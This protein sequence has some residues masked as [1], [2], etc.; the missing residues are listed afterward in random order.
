MAVPGT[1]LSAKNASV[2]IDGNI[3]YAEE[4]DVEPEAALIEGNSFEGGGYE[5]DIFGLIKATVTI[6]FWWDAG[7]NPYDSPLS[8]QVATVLSNVRCFMAGPSSP[9]WSFPL[10]NVMGTPHVASVKD[11][12]MVTLKGK[13]KGSFS[14]PTGNA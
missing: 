3:C 11:K 14:Y 7:A 12:H 2:R 8:I 1:P 9:G 6:K 13:G 4:W 5:S 10:L